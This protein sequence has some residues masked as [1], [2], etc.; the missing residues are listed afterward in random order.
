MARRVVVSGGG[1]GIGRAIASRFAAGGDAVAI[2]GRRRDVLERTAVEINRDVGRDAVTTHPA[3]LEDPATVARLASELV[4]GGSIDVLV[5]NAGGTI[6][7]TGTSLGDVADQWTRT[8]RNN[9]LSTVL[10]TEALLPD[11]ARPGGRIIA[12]SSVAAVR[13]AG[14]Y[15]AAKAALHAW[16][17]D[18]AAKVGPDGITV[19]AI[20][21]GFVPDTEFWDGRRTD[22][23]AAPRIAGT[24]VKRAGTPDEIAEAVA[25]LASPLSGFT[26]GQI[27][28]VNGGTTL[29]R[30]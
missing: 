28:Q 17:Y 22:Q 25:Y 26:T 15:G 11:I 21:P 24:L 27:L 8:F 5:N 29:G 7:S 20:A 3:D 10:L 13:G 6:E 30:G 12:M 4:A 2:V 9:V 1:T 19:N 14:A 23:V 16:V 18:L